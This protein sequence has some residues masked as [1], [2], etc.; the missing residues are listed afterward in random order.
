MRYEKVNDD[1]L[2]CF[3]VLLLESQIGKS[4]FISTRF[5]NRRAC[6]NPSKPAS[7]FQALRRN[8]IFL[9]GIDMKKYPAL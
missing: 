6:G 4:Y 7:S 1:D 2:R 8:F 3:W 9:C 5:S